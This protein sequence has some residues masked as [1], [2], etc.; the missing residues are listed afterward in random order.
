MTHRNAPLTPVG[1]LRLVRRVQAGRPIAHV[2]AEAGIA[3]QTLSKWVGRY[4]AA[5]EDG[6]LDRR[7]TPGHS[8]H[9]M[10]PEVVARIEYLRR[11]HKYSAR[12]IVH[13]LATEGVSVSTATVGRWLSRLGLNRRRFLDPNGATNRR[14]RRITA[15]YPGHMV[16]VDVKK[17]GRIPDGGGWRIHG[18]GSAGDHAARRQRPGYAFFH[19]ALDGYSRLAYTELLDTETADAAV[20][21]FARARAFFRIHGI[22]EVNRV[23]TD[24]APCYASPRFTRSL[25]STRHQRIRPFTPRHNGKVERYHRTLAE[26]LCYAHAWNSETERHDALRRWLIHF[27]YHRPHTATGDLPPATRLHTGVTNVMIGHI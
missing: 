17:I 8:P 3:R 21:F 9:Q 5:G 15:R 1:R 24:N 11:C 12:L 20:G 7:S 18:R 13:T 23:I 2:A 22:D 6:L 10:P 14:R 27:N 26:E 19:T 4:R 25:G 16:H